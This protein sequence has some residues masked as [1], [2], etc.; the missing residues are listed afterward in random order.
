MSHQIQSIARVGQRM[1]RA[2]YGQNH[3]RVGAG[4]EGIGAFVRVQYSDLRPDGTLGP[5]VFAFACVPRAGTRFSVI[6]PHLCAMPDGRLLI[7]MPTSGVGRAAWACVL[8]NPLDDAEW[9]VGPF[10]FL[11]IGFVG[12]PRVIDF[13]VYM[14]VN[15]PV[16]GIKPV[17]VWQG[18]RVF[19]LRFDGE[20]V[21]PEHL[22][23]I[24]PVE[25]RAE[26]S[27]FQETSLVPLGGR[28][29]MA[30][31]RTKKGQFVSKDERGDGAWSEPERLPFR[32]I[33]S[34]Y[35]AAKSP[36]GRI[37]YAGNGPKSR[38]RDNMSVRLSDDEARTWPER[39]ANVFFKSVC[40][41]A[42][43]EFGAD[44]RGL[45]NGL[46]YVAFDHG[47]GTIKDPRN[48]ER[49]LNG[50]ITAV[51][52]EEELAAGKAEPIQLDRVNT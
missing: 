47:R 22:S 23:T 52:R 14:T 11:G 41:Y 25:P 10:C 3:L 8:D 27:T 28:G 24:P 6:D 15:E 48:P 1:W 35:D 30:F 21:V 7:T 50:L 51:F 46:I 36:S 40:S 9:R 2:N 29:F 39:K 32:T 16:N 44:A 43:I 37:V 42:S 34:R 13:R 17:D 33:P 45:Y 26:T 20:I 31:F 19:R 38:G 5:W 4:G 18:A 49:Y 12:R